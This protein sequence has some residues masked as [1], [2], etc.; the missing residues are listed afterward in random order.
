MNLNIR[1][2]RHILNAGNHAAMF[3]AHARN[4]FVCA[5]WNRSRFNIVRSPDRL[6]R[7]TL[8]L[9]INQQLA[10]RGKVCKRVALNSQV[11]GLSFLGLSSLR[12]SG[13]LAIEATTFSYCRG[14][15]T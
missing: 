12:E 4:E 8:V 13:M 15:R 10:N 11:H 2:S 3:F 14:L 9:A 6:E 7:E 1:K 5:F